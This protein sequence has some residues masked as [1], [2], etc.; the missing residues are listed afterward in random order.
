MSGNATSP[1][2]PGPRDA[3]T[4]TRELRTAAGGPLA[5]RLSRRYLE[6]HCLLPLDE[7]EE[8]VRVAV[9]RPADPTAIDELGWFFGRRIELVEAPLA[10]VQAALMASAVGDGIGDGTPLRSADVELVTDSED[11]FDDV[12]AL[13]DRAPVI[14]LVNVLI[15]EALQSRASDL[16]LEST[17]DGLRV[18][19]RID[20]VLHDVSHP[21]R[22]YQAAVVSRIKIM[23]SM[24][25]AERRLPQDGRIRLRLA[26]R[27]VDLRVSTVPSIHG[28][29]VVLRILDRGGAA[30]DLEELGMPADIRGP[31][32]RLVEQPHGIV[33]VTGPTGSGKTTTL[34]A[35]LSALN[36]PGSKIITVEDPVEYQLAGI[37]QIPV[38]R[39][40]GLGFP[41]ALRS[42]LR[43][44]P[45][46]L[47][48]GEMRDAETADIA[49]QSA[50]TGHLVFSTLHTNDAPGGVTRLLDMGVPAFL[51]GATLR[52]VLAQRL[53]R[54]VCRDCAEP[55]SLD[56][57]ELAAV[58][59]GYEQLQLGEEFLR[60]A[61]CAECAG[62]GYRGRTGIYELMIVDRKL[63]D[64]IGKGASESSI[65]KTA[66]RAGL[67]PLRF[68][69]FA[70]ARTGLT[71]VEEV[72][73]VTRG[74]P[75]E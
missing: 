73:R 1:S 34:Y 66:Y 38:N 20:G 63:T 35:A 3:T 61:G 32:R 47:M 33:L 43:H 8:V 64:A 15:L 45:D 72:L 6:D 14:K 68:D 29:S 7:T 36:R 44:D 26:D 70:K 9:G 5:R 41:N 2:D 22:E 10:E 71:T 48:I 12:R 46:V 39:K 69:G 75:S 11:A 51:L 67:L 54:R 57:A 18:R 56:P 65:R 24:N 30:R 19:H 55:Y 50:L 27:E 49:I 23:A 17:A 60:G 37:T 53:V 16:H 58:G 52:G 13:A 62:T 42:I 25:I 31:F 59:S 74:E 28:E 4:L 21:P 40:A